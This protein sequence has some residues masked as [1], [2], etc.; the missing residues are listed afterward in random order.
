MRT[1]RHITTREC[2]R[3]IRLPAHYLVLLVVPSL[4]FFLY[5]YIYDEQ[6]ADHL[7]V[8]MWDEDRSAVSRQFSFLLQ[9]V[10]TLR[11]T[12]QVGSIDELQDLLQKGEVLGAIHFPKNM[13]R[14][15]KS[16]HPVHVVVY[17]NAAA[18]VPAKLIYKEAAQVI[19]T[20]GSGVILQKF[21]KTGMDKG[22]AMAL[23]QP[24]ALVPYTLYNPTYNYQKY[25]VPGLITVALQ[26]IMIMVGVLLLNYEATTN[27]REELWRLAKGSAS[28]V[29]AGKTIAHL[30]IAWINFILV[31][32]VI[33]P[34]F[35]LGITAAAGKF[36]VI[37][38][39]L[40]LACLGIGQMIS[41]LFSDTMLA[42]DVALFYTSPAF[43]FSG[44]TFPRWAMPWYDQY[45]A[46]IMPYTHFL[47]GFFKVYYMDL[48]LSYAR[49]EIGYL[50]LFI[51]I[52]FSVAILVYQQ[53]LNKL[54]R[55]V[56]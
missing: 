35:N 48:P 12:K 15:I 55:A 46:N 29:I 23:V 1:I 20:A 26:M 31:A 18:V 25:L 19:I 33:F 49:S 52:T 9:Q 2:K 37:Y 16:R 51:A 11:F 17:T 27:T 8:A 38:T 22:K 47:D 13:E 28:A 42:T 39:L 34:V 6:Q 3:I 54:Q 30:L 40:C 5:A 44:F 43:V 41:A 56:T 50:L 53:Q 10:K 4:L 21:I 7:P 45:Y 14:D 32:F 24:I 36:F